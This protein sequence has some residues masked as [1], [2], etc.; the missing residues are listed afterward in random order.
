MGDDISQLA[1]AVALARRTR[2]VIRQ[3]LAIALGVIV[4]LIAVTTTGVAGIGPAVVFHEGS[5]IVVIANALRLLR[6]RVPV[7]APRQAA[8]E[9]LVEAA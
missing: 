8:R 3:N 1:Y 9:S 7:P 6:F 2:R 4:V 5:T